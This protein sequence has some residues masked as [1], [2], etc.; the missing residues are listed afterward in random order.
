[1]DS[2]R[3]GEDHMVSSKLPELK[4]GTRYEIECI[5][6]REVV[7]T[8]ATN[9]MVVHSG[10]EYVMG[11]TFGD[12]PESR[13]YVGLCNTVDSLPGDTMD[14]HS[15]VEYI[16][17]AS[18]QRPRAG[19]LNTGLVG[20]SWTYT[21]YNLQSMIVSPASLRGAFLT[22]NDIKGNNGGMLYGVAPFQE[23]KDVSPGDSII[24]TITTSVEG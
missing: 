12:T 9:N 4:M 23:A 6:D 15:F 7:W 17:T 3:S 8:V 14:S 19:F 16:G 20:D 1:M 11:R 21:A 13:M 2:S 22:D 18:T 5:R 24:I 10:L